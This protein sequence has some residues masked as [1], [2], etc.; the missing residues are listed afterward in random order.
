MLRRQLHFYA[1]SVVTEISG[2]LR[3]DVIGILKLLL[4]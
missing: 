4:F 1:G 2:A 3:A